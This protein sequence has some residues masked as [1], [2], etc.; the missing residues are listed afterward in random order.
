GRP[1]TKSSSAQALHSQSR[2]EPAASRS[3]SHSA[4]TRSIVSAWPAPSL[5]GRE[6]VV[7]L[8]TSRPQV[9][10]AG[11]GSTPQRKCSIL[12]PGRHN[13]RPERS[14]FPGKD[15]HARACT[16]GRHVEDI[17]NTFK[18]A[19]IGATALALVFS[20]ASASAQEITRVR[21]TIDKVDGNT[22]LVKSREG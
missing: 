6:G 10:G 5:P 15:N 7:G 11:S 18:Y 16:P 20:A 14:R 12:S 21:G 4:Q 13:T 19:A 8:A 1:R 22:L 2:Q 3:I 9:I 17:M